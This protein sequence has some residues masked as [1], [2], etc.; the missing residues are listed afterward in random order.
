MDEMDGELGQF[1]I[2][3]KGWSTIKTRTFAY[4][5]TELSDVLV[6]KFEPE[7][8]QETWKLFVNRSTKEL[9]SGMNNFNELGGIQT[10]LCSKIHLRQP[11][12]RLNTKPY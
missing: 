11:I 5:I 12:I 7:P 6:P 1:E 2:S 3:Y 10:E 8:K 4:F 9:A